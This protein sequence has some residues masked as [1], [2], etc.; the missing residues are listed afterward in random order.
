MIFK[1]FDRGSLKI[2]PLSDR[3]NKM[4]VADIHNLDYWPLYNESD[5]DRLVLKIAKARENNKEVILM[6]GAHAIRR[7]N[8]RFIIDLI[9][10][11]IITHVAT[12]GAAAIHDFELALIGATAENVED[13]IKEGEFGNWEETGRYINKAINNGYK[14]GLGYGESI[15]QMI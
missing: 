2:L 7:G 10:R 12:N 5:L 11:G 13:Y 1:E 3:K 8:S 9:N 6:M 14:A 15:G 4:T